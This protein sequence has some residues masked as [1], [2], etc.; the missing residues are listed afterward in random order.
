MQ[1]KRFLITGGSG[2]LGCNLALTLSE[3]IDIV[4]TYFQHP[5][6]FENMEMIKMDITNA[7]ETYE[8]IEKYKPNVLIHC[9]GETRV[10]YCEDHPN[11][12]FKINV[13]GTEN[14]VQSASHLKVKF[15]YIST[16]SVFDGLQ[17]MYTEE[18][19][20]NPINIYAQT[21]LAGEK[22]VQK[23][24]NDYLIV[25]TNIFGWN[26]GPKLGLAEWI[27]KQLEKGEKVPG[28]SDIYFS[29]ILTTDLAKI[30][31]EMIISD[32][33]GLYHVCASERCSKFDFA[34]MICRVFGKDDDLIQPTISEKAGLKAPR[35]KDTSLD[36]KKITKT[37]GKPMPKI[38]EGIRH[39]KQQFES[40]Y[41]K[42]LF[43]GSTHK[44]FIV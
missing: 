34:R 7:K 44:E 36:I 4:A 10:D 27:L 2:L 30:L 42:K 9:A 18:A 33:E 17:G 40:G 6:Y 8:A 13:E 37:L 38:M 1:V 24:A 14:L 3:R 41:V 15:V 43:S 11:E 16:D 23:F 12:A 25:R 28:F 21:K 39:F 31:N 22:I 26:P 29:P 19:N 32:L 35:P 20:P 5:L